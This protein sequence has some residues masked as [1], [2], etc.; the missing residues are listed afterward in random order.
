MAVP[1]RKR[2]KRSVRSTIVR[3]VVWLFAFVP[4][5]FALAFAGLVGR[6]AWRL[7][8]RTRAQVL[9]QLAIAFPEKTP[10]E[11]EAI[12][13]G[14]ARRRRA[15]PPISRSLRR[16]GARGLVRRRG[17]GPRDGHVVDFVEIP[18]DPD[19]PDRDAEVARVTGACSAVLEAA[20]RA[21]PAEWVWMHER[22]K[23]QPE[24]DARDPK[25]SRCRKALSF[26]AGSGRAR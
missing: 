5:R 20:I 2:V 13:R 14:A 16:P 21:S 3:A 23:T 8:A 10:W 26:R 15:G 1:L 4:L 24:I 12:G 11:R 7:A 25:Q 19:P 6:A 9:A 22:W 18:Y 17:P